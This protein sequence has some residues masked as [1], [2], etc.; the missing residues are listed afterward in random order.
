MNWRR[1]TRQRRVRD[2]KREPV[3]IVRVTVKPRPTSKWIERTI[4]IVALALSLGGHIIFAAVAIVEKKAQDEYL[5]GITSVR[6]PEEDK[7]M[8]E[9]PPPPPPPPPTEVGIG[10]GEGNAAGQDKGENKD[11]ARKRIEDQ[12]VANASGM[13]GALDQG[14]EAT[15][16]MFDANSLELDD[17]LEGLAN[18]G[19][20]DARGTSGLGTLG[21]GMGGGGS[22]LGIGGL[23]TKGRGGGGR[24]YGVGE[25]GK[26]GKRSAN[27]NIETGNPTIA[28]ALDKSIV[29]RI[30][31]K[32][33]SQIRYCYQKELNRN[34]NLYG[35][36]TIKFTIAGDGNVSSSVVTVT[37]MKNFAVEDCVARTIK[38]IVF[39]APKGGGIVVVTYPF[40]FKAEGAN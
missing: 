39:P 4:L 14:G 18:A 32:H 40:I 5:M 38:R 35:K 3:P 27:I 37:T 16:R 28:G 7:K 22:A 30:I 11:A 24:G 6:P 15:D 29:G 13:L 25:A 8:E 33:Y 17:K 21:A 9:L 23:G 10:T 34:P 2:E 36:I 12:K 20:L 19:T 31:Q 26:L 1:T